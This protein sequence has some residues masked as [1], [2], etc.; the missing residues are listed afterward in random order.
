[1]NKKSAARLIIDLGMT[2]LLLCAYAYR[3]VGDAAHEWIG[4]SVFA[5]FIVHNLINRRWYK[6]IFRGKYTPRR[7][8][9]AAVNAALVLTMAAV[10]ATGLMQSRTVFAFLGLSGGMELRLIHTTAA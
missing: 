5:L 7:I 10:L 8:I 4:I 6:T 3:I 9:M 2:I 1:M